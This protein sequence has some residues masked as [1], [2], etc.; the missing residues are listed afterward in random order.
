MCGVVC[1][2]A[3]GRVNAG[4]GG[5]E[6]TLVLDPEEAELPR[7]AGGG[8]FAFMFSSLLGGNAAHAGEGLASSLLWTNYTTAAP[9]DVAELARAREL[10]E[11]GARQVWLALRESVENMGSSKP[12]VKMEQQS[13][14]P[15]SLSSM[16]VDEEKVEI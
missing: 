4:E 5:Q 12:F 11:K 15:H 2:V 1:A 14:L 3:V 13:Q 8:C 9:F 10:A 6:A 7:L 16:E